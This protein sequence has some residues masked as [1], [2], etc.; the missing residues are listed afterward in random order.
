MPVYVMEWIDYIELRLMADYLHER[1]QEE[2]RHAFRRIALKTKRSYL[3]FT[4]DGYPDRVVMCTRLAYRR[5]YG[6][7]IGGGRGT[8]RTTE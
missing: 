7:G 6:T 3:A 2:L 5:L 8:A 1:V 4:P